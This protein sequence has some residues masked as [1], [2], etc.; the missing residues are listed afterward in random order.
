MVKLLRLRSDFETLESTILTRKKVNL[1]YLL[2]FAFTGLFGQIENCNIDLEE[3][4]D[5]TKFQTK[6]TELHQH[7]NIFDFYGELIRCQLINDFNA[8]VM[9]DASL[10]EKISN[11]VYKNSNDSIVTYGELLFQFNSEMKTD[12]FLFKKEEI[13]KRDNFL[14]EIHQLPINL[15]DWETD[16]LKLIKL[17]VDAAQLPFWKDHIISE[18]LEG[19]QYSYFFGIK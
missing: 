3:K 16:S 9:H 11:N 2:L 6:S 12:E 5:L 17:G 4:I 8:R 15:D 7:Y 10:F 14:K 1:C 19:Q 18:N 13:I